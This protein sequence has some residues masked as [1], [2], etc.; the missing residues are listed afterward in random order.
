MND[1]PV[2]YEIISKLGS[3]MGIKSSYKER[4]YK[5]LCISSIDFVSCGKKNHALYMYAPWFFPCLLV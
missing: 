5:E 4:S 2:N 3:Y 1:I